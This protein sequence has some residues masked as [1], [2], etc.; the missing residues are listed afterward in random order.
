[1]TEKVDAGNLR[2]INY[3]LKYLAEHAALKS[4]KCLRVLDV[5]CGAGNISFALLEAGYDVTGIDLDQASITYCQN[6]HK[7]QKARFLLADIEQLHTDELFDV[8]IAS[9]VIEH[10]PQPE[11]AISAMKDH[12]VDDGLFIVTTPNGYSLWE[13]SINNFAQKMRQYPFGSKVYDIG[14][15]AYFF[16]MDRK[17]VVGTLNFSGHG[18]VNFFTFNY[19]CDLLG[20]NGFNIVSIEKQGLAISLLPLRQIDGWARAE[21][22]LAQ[23]LPPAFCGWWGLIA[24]RGKKDDEVIIG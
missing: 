12:L 21:D 15:K 19:L 18:H 17:K 5:G 22:N 24:N 14:K 4:K 8:I 9:E 11:L 16:S 6:N 7:F 23:F 2:K 1:M 20:K 13:I 10:I 3:I